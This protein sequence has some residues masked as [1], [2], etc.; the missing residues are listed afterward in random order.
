MAKSE[1]VLT[2]EKI[3]SHWHD[4]SLKSSGD[5]LDRKEGKTYKKKNK[6]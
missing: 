4:F 6:N 2:K 5:I 1:E 3:L